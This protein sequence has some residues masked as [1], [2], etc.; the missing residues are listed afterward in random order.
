MFSL[1]KFETRLIYPP[2]FLE[3]IN[4]KLYQD[5]ELSSASWF[6]FDVANKH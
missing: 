3:K 5:S 1:P 2:Y 6:T 4:F